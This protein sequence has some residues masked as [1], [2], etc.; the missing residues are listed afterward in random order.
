MNTVN[1]LSYKVSI[2]IP[3]YKVEPYL[4]TCIE[5]V[6]NQTYP[7]IEI[8]LVDDG[9]PDKCGEIC[10]T[11]ALK[12]N[13]VFVIHKQNEG[14]AKARIDGFKQSSGEYV[15]FIDADDYVENNYIEKL[16]EPVIKYQ[17]DMVV[18]QNF[19]KEGDHLTPCIR[20]VKGLFDEHQIK[21]IISQ[22]YLYN[23]K[24]RGAGIP[25][26]LCTKLIKRNFVLDGLIAGS[27]LWWGEDQ[28]ASFYI[29][30]KIKT[31]FVMPDCLYYY[32]KHKGQATQVY[33]TSLWENQL[34]AYKRYKD[35]DK[36][37]LL[38]EQLPLRTW[39]FTIMANIYYKMPSSIKT[40]FDFCNEL[41]RI[42]N[43][44]AWKDLFH[45]NSIGLGWR[46]DIKFWLLKL[47]QYK[48]F[49]MLFLYKTYKKK[50]SLIED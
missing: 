22:Q 47:K 15:T 48:F 29:L 1:N 24:T 42:E 17:A 40:C 23:K 27:G 4:E 2:I 8:I 9:S 13:R 33:K 6:I 14:V 11:Y 41:K 16:I 46:D 50:T 32:V 5:S 19:V 26:F 34:E 43:H 44:L 37:G 10:D 28:V 31:L 38:K 35:I 7:N 21:T 25:V 49:Y 36:E 20:A 30:T 39:K 18:C 3:V 12:D 45:R